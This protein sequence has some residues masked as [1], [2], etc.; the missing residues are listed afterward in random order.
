[1]FQLYNAKQ[2]TILYSEII[3]LPVTCSLRFKDQIKIMIKIQNSKNSQLIILTVQKW[4]WNSMLVK[5]YEQL[6]TKYFYL[7]DIRVTS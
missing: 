1:M 2:Y 7:Q 3:R 5:F 6:I 4:T